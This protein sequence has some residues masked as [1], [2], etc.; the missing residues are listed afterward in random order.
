MKYLS[1]DLNT[2]FDLK[3]V[4]L[5]H[6]SFHGP[7]C[8]SQLSPEERDWSWSHVLINSREIVFWQ[9]GVVRRDDQ[10]FVGG[11]GNK[12]R[13]YWTWNIFSFWKFISLTEKCMF[14]WV[15]DISYQRLKSAVIF[16]IR[17]HCCI[18]KTRAR[19]WGRGRGVGRVEIGKLRF[20]RRRRVKIF[21]FRRYSR[22]CLEV[23]VINWKMVLRT[24]SLVGGR[25]SH[26]GELLAFQIHNLTNN[27]E[28]DYNYTNFVPGHEPMV[29]IVRVRFLFPAPKLVTIHHEPPLKLF[30][31][32]S[33]VIFELLLTLDFKGKN[34]KTVWNLLSSNQNNQISISLKEKSQIFTF[35]LV[36][37]WFSNTLCH[38]CTQQITEYK[39][40][41]LH[42]VQ[43]S[44]S[45]SGK[46]Q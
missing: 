39:E 24:G 7:R 45:I 19:T 14:T 34:I 35:L 20:G 13:W 11:G 29:D 8:P 43:S 3:W 27:N 33:R 1:W 12:S 21:W 25:W 38:S 42:L 10:F 46:Y 37:I 28:F 44:D 32:V 31:R 36:L 5:K 23:R 41:I 2:S 16:Q 17:G 6:K 15:W 26:V 22:G 30:P 9:V 18:G 40:Y 4:L